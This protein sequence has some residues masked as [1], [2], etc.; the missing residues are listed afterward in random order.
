MQGW[1]LAPPTH[2]RGQPEAQLFLEVE[3]VTFYCFSALACLTDSEM[4]RPSRN[5]WPFGGCELWQGRGV[6]RVGVAENKSLPLVHHPED[7]SYPS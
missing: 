7:T 1:W 4:I 3:S 6:E 5:D 2:P